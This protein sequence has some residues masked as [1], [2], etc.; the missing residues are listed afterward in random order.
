[1]T[2]T[3]KPTPFVPSIWAPTH[4]TSTHAKHPGLGMAN[5]PHYPGDTEET[6][7]CERMMLP[8]AWTGKGFEAAPAP[9]M[10]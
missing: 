6:Y 7:A 8:F 10:T 4:T 3:R 1:M 5:M 2:Q 9:S